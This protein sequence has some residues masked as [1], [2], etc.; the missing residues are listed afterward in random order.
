MVLPPTVFFLIFS[1]LPM[2]GMVVAFKKFNYTDGLFRSPWC[3]FENF[4][5]FFIGGK[6]L[7]VMF[8]TVA[9][10]FAFIVT[11]LVVQV[12][13]AIFLSE[14]GSRYF[15]KITQSMMFLPYFLSWVVVGAFIYNIFNYEYGSL[16]TLLKS[17]NMEPVNVYEQIWLWKFILVACNT[18]KWTGYGSLIYLAA[19]MGIDNQLFEAAEIDGASK[20]HKI[21]HIT[22]P[23]ITP[24]IIVLTIMAVGRIFRGDFGMFYQVTGNNPL[25][26]ST[27]D[28]IDTYVF[29]ALLDLQDFGMA[30]AAGM[31]QSVLCFFFLLFTNAIVRKVDKSYALF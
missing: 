24:Q 29:R 23:M 30:S 28:V 25:L 31:L 3:G 17:L 14:I 19:I 18:W 8:N 12:A 4:K 6:A 5:F 7:K 21:R 26:F 27:T 15:K 20:F 16:N 22:I 9:Y 11:G 10:N 2:A 1:Y 13:A